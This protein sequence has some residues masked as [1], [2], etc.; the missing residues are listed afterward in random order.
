MVW[1]AFVSSPLGT[2]LRVK[3]AFIVSA[4][5][6]KHDYALNKVLEGLL[7]LDNVV[8][9]NVDGLYYIASLDPDMIDLR[10][11]QIEEFTVAKLT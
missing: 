3:K 8:I 10:T 7:D 4:G 1:F 2:N 5:K 11:A 6:D 9:D